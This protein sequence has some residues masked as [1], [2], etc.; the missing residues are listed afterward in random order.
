MKTK[1]DGSLDLRYKENKDYEKLVWRNRLL[2][3]AVLGA[4][5]GA[6]L[7]IS[8]FRATHTSP[9]AVNDVFEVQEVIAQ[10][11]SP[12]P[13][14]KPVRKYTHYNYTRM[15][16]YQDIMLGLQNRYVE[17]EDAAELIAREASFNPS[18]I[19]PT[20][21]ACGLPQALPCSKMDCDLTDIDCQLDWQKDYI[22]GRYGTVTK[23]L[24]F[25]D[26][27]GWY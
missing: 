25:H 15:P 20:S 5:A 21:G 16:R 2:G 24:Q 9:E 4:L 11:P 6:I 18:A 1:K 23:A 7:T 12:T 3:T 13:T 14:P 10:E 8:I 22:A 17:F 19:N 26:I 27:N